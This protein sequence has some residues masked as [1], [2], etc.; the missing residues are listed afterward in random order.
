MLRNPVGQQVKHMNRTIV[1]KMRIVLNT[2]LEV[3][4]MAMIGKLLHLC[5]GGEF[6]TLILCKET[7]EGSSHVG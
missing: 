4:L 5:V 2:F 1:R 6:L 7:K 3:V